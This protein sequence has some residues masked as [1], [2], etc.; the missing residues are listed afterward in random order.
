M[1]TLKSLGSEIEESLEKMVKRANKMEAYLNR[2]VYRKYQNFQ[3]KRW[4]TENADVGTWQRLDSKYEGRKKKKYK[5]YPGS[6]Q[7][8]MIAT[9][10]LVGSV[11]GPGA[12]GSFISIKTGF[13]DHKKLVDSHKIVIATTTPYAE[14]ADE[15]RSITEFPQSFYDDISKDLGEF[16]F[17]GTLNG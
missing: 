10:R 9:T 4:M 8:M 11:I 3:A 2:V 17:E 7:K 16:L 1:A 15:L 14:Y 6:G 5:S 12:G 13:Q